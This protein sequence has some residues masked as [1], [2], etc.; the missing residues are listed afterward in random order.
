MK[1]S[2]PKSAVMIQHCKENNIPYIDMKLKKKL[3]NKETN[4]QT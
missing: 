1:N 3:K 2:A 4:K